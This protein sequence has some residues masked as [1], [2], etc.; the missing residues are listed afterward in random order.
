MI[1]GG[2]ASVGQDPGNLTEAVNQGLWVSPNQRDQR[3]GRVRWP[4]PPNEIT[5]THAKSDALSLPKIQPRCLEGGVGVVRLNIDNGL[6]VVGENGVWHEVQ[7]GKGSKANPY[8][9]SKEGYL[10]T[11]TRKRGQTTAHNL[12]KL[13]AT[14]ISP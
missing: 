10:H 9:I 14:S 8:L 5:N 6:S 2:L 1:P 3:V 4:V 11:G 12:S 7:R 13:R